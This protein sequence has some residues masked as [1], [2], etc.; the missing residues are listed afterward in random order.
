LA[1]LAEFGP[2]SQAELGR[3]C[4]IDRSDMVALVNE[5]SAQGRIM[6][7]PDAVDRRRNVITIT[8]AGLQYLVELRGLVDGAQQ[9]LL[10]GL[11]TPE[12]ADL[13]ELLSRVVESHPEFVPGGWAEKGGAR[14]GE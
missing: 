1:T 8:A 4:G 6:R 3:R 5:L 14:R 13:V 2:L 9:D 10:A 7:A 12:R 11:S